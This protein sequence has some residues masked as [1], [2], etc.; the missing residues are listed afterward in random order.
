MDLV[1]IGA[2]VPVVANGFLDGNSVAWTIVGN[3]VGDTDGLMDD[4]DVGVLVATGIGAV[5]DV[6]ADTRFTHL[7]VAASQ[8]SCV[9]MVTLLTVCRDVDPAPNVTYSL[10]KYA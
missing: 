4:R 3:F 6:G 5:G 1:P 2:S 7:S 10:Q 8:P 9:I